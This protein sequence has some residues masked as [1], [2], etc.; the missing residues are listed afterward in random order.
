MIISA[1]T[2]TEVYSLLISYIAIDN[3][4]TS[5]FNGNYQYSSLTSAAYLNIPLN[6]Q[7][8]PLILFGGINGFIMPNVQGDTQFSSNFRNNS[9]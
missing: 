1:T 3:S 4:S 8:T 6:I 9:L 2:Q 7:S 5:L